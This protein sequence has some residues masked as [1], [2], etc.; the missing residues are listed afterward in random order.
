[1]AYQY[2]FLLKGGQPWEHKAG[3]WLF[4]KIAE[5]AFQY[6]EGVSSAATKFLDTARSVEKIRSE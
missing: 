1:M 5:G 2:G 3:L 4:R 6:H